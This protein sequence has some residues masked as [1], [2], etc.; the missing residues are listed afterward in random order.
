MQII[1]RYRHMHSTYSEMSMSI[2]RLQLTTYGVNSKKVS[3]AYIYRTNHYFLHEMPVAERKVDEKLYNNFYESYPMGAFVY[4]NAAHS[5]VCV[6]SK[7]SVPIFCNDLN[8][9]N[10]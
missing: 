2:D 8:R 9:Y 6:D 5:Q 3:S 7:P 1:V 10:H 4:W